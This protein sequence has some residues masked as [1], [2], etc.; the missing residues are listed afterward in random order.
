MEEQTF[1][2]QETRIEDGGEIENGGKPENPEP[3]DKNPALH[4]AQ[5]PLTDLEQLRAELSEAKAQ[6]L[7]AY[8]RALLAENGGKI[9][10]ELVVGST[11][12]ELE[13]SLEVA[14]KAF[15]A[16]KATALAELS[17]QHVPVGNPIRQG[18]NVESMSPMEKIAYGLKRD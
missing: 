6:H 11:V 9:V 16:A 10:P 2:D 8:R 12:E 7:E 4:S 14:R 3:G 17:S 18:P 13:Q 1:N 5:T 15:A